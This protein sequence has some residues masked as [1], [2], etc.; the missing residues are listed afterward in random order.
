MQRPA[1]ARFKMSHSWLPACSASIKA[2]HACQHAAQSIL[3]DTSLSM[4]SVAITAAAGRHLRNLPCKAEAVQQRGLLWMQS[5]WPSGSRPRGSTCIVALVLH[6]CTQLWILPEIS[7]AKQPHPSAEAGPPALRTAQNLTLQ[8]FLC[9]Q[10]R[11][12]ALNER[13]TSAPGSRQRW[14]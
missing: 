6:P 2:R 14:L 3:D 8:N 13:L 12:T 5:D 10:M 7:A 1:T 11:V 4:R 9:R